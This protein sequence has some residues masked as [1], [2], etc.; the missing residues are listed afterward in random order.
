MNA[1]EFF[2][3][4]VSEVTENEKQKNITEGFTKD[5]VEKAMKKSLKKMHICYMI[6]ILYN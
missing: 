6:P 3:K 4:F 5:I 2:D 1:K